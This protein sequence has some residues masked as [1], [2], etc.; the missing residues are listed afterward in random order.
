MTGEIRKITGYARPNH[1]LTETDREKNADAT[2]AMVASLG[3]L[4]GMKASGIGFEQLSQLMEADPNDDLSGLR[5]MAERMVDDP[6]GTFDDYRDEQPIS[7]DIARRWLIGTGRVSET[8]TG[9]LAAIDTDHLT[10]SGLAI[11][12]SADGGRLSEAYQ[13]ITDNPIPMTERVIAEMSWN[14]TDR[15]SQPFEK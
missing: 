12:T 5:L 11:A 6:F 14:I 10:L 1:T 8:A 7:P 2:R 4:L 3:G 15:Y 9:E 13:S